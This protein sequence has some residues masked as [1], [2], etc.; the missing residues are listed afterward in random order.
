MIIPVPV[1]FPIQIHSNHN[2]VAH[3][4]SNVSE[5]DSNQT[6]QPC[7]DDNASTSKKKHALVERRVKRG[8]G[9]S[10]VRR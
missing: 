5:L 2:S 1:F 3:D 6:G 4:G 9:T 8:Q 10:L 7:L